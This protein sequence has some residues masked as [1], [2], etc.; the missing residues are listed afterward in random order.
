MR[1]YTLKL[2][3]GLRQAPNAHARFACACSQQRHP[4]QPTD[5]DTTFEKQ[6]RYRITAVVGKE[7][8]LGVENLHGSGMIAGETSAAYEDTF[9]ISHDCTLETHI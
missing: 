2:I 3:S 5:H 8:G 7:D 4:N 6:E 9:T 1:V